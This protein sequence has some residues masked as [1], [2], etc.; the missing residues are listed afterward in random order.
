MTDHA[1]PDHSHA[2]LDDAELDD[3]QLLGLMLSGNREAAAEMVERMA[4]LIR[5]MVYRLTGWHPE[6]ADIV[7]EVFL[8]MLENAHG[9]R[10]ESTFSTWVAAIAVNRSRRFVRNLRRT[11]EAIYPRRTWFMKLLF[12]SRS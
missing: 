2:E 9:Y 1:Q 6:S 5:R 8:A 10:G 4:P 3:A 12:P 7:Q 11:I